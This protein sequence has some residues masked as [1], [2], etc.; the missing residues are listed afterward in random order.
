M[1]VTRLRRDHGVSQ[2]LTPAPPWVDCA[3]T[4]PSRAAARSRRAVAVFEV[5]R[6][7]GRVC[8]R[9]RVRRVACGSASVCAR[10]K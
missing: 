10:E 9:V 1:R 8:A 2:A 5:I 7:A 3:P 6:I 4:P